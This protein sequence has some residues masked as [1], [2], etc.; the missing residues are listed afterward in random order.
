MSYIP[1]ELPTANTS[2]R[3]TDEVTGVDEAHPLSLPNW[4]SLVTAD[5]T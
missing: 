3:V 1:A 4:S 5:G 2:D